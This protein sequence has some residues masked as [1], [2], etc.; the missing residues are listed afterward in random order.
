M[1]EKSPKPNIKELRKR[2]DIEGLIEALR[3]TDWH[4][5][6]DAAEALGELK[7]VRAI[8]HLIE[9]LR[10]DNAKVRR[11]VAFALGLSLFWC[12]ERS[13]REFMGFQ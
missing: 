11:N 4:V 10:D 5:R 13:R 8:A 7:D 6:R 9:A 3:H 12:C 2:H 1:F